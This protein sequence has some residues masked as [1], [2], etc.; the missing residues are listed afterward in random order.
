LSTSTPGAP[1]RS[2]GALRPL[3]EGE[4]RQILTG[5]VLR[6]LAPL[7]GSGC[8]RG[9]CE[10]IA[11]PVVVRDA[12]TLRG[13]VSC[14]SRPW[15]R[16]SELSLLE[17]PYPLSRA[18]PA[19]L[20]VRARPPNGATVSE[21]FAVSFPVRADPWPRLAFRLAGLGG[22]D[23]GFPRSLGTARLRV[24]ARVC[25]VSPQI[26]RARRTRRPARPLRSFSPL[27][28][29]FSRDRHPGQGTTTQSVLS[30]AL[31]SLVH[32]PTDRGSGLRAD[33]RG[34]DEPVPR[35]PSRA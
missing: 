18:V 25:G 21:G 16:P 9:A 12:P 11:P 23:E 31:S 22:H 34:R 19:S 17:E 20:W 28:S 33:G 2:L 14:R 8:V 4:G 30:W 3:A 29:P 5:A 10:Q 6:V 15:S 1:C 13:L 27:E 26:G 35:T 32:S 7:D 24:T